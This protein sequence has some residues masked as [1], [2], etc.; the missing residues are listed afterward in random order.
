MSQLSTQELCLEFHES[1]VTNI[2]N[3]KPCD[4]G[5]IFIP[6]LSR[7]GRGVGR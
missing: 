3:V 7:R 5:Y 4:D 1:H 2:I 6:L